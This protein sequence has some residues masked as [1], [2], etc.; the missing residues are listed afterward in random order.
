MTWWDDM[1]REMESLRRDMMRMMDET[2]M[3]RRPYSRVSFLPGLRA[4]SYPLLNISEDKD[5]LFVEAL[6]PGIDPE[7]LNISF[8]NNQLTIVGEKKPAPNGSI[9]AEAFHRSERAAGRFNRTVNLPVQ[10]DTDKVK[11]DYRNGLIYIEM[12]KSELS[13]SRQIEVQVS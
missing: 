11:A 10:V 4:R 13:K 6:A 5:S 9:K 2:P 1:F 3:R 8:A 12:P 7:S